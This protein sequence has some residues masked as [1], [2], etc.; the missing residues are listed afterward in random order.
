MILYEH[1]NLGR[2]VPMEYVKEAVD[3][4]K[5]SVDQRKPRTGKKRSKKK[6]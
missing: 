6:R 5:R 2:V 4:L 3:F 1:A